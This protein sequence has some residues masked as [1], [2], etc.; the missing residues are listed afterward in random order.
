MAKRK[1]RVSRQSKQEWL[2]ARARD[3]MRLHNATEFAPDVVA[4]WLVDTRQYE[5]APYSVVRRCRQE[6]T[7]ALRQQKMVDPQGREVRALCSVRYRDENGELKATWS[8]LFEASP[9]H[10]RQSAQQH[11]RSIRG[12]ILQHHRNVVSWNDNNVHGAQLEL[13]GYNFNLDVAEA[14]MP[15]EYPDEPEATGDTGSAPEP[16]TP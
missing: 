2:Q 7:R 16:P 10:M 5:E 12:E 13:F 4:A 3:W 1:I 11:R 6:L 14:E 15:T 8:T 9:K